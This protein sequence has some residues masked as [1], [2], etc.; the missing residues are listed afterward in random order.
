M[1]AGNGRVDHLHGGV[2]S[3]SQC[4]HYPGPYACAAPANKAVVA[5]GVRTETEVLKQLKLTS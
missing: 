3:A 1:N 5:G 2:M 4:V